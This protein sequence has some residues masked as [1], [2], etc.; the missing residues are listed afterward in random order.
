MDKDEILGQLQAVIAQRGREIELL[1]DRIRKLEARLAIYENAHTP[2][3][4]KRGGNRKKR[5]NKGVKGTPG[6]KKGHT[7]V[8]RPIAKPDKHVEVTTERCPDC[9][10]ELGSPFRIES[11]II[12]DIPEPQPVI[13]TEFK[14]AHYTCPRCQ[15]E[16]VATDADCPKEGR[17]GNNTIARATL[18]KYEDRLPHRK[19]GTALKRDYGLKVSPASILDFTRRGSDAIRSEY[20]QILE[21]IRSAPI[22]YVD[23]TGIRVQ[24]KKYWI[25]IFT[26]PEDTFVAVRKSRGMKVLMEV[27]TRRFKGI[28]VCDGW[29]PYARFTKR[30]QRCWAHLLR[31]S[32]YLAGKFA[33]AV[34]LHKALVRLYQRLDDALKDDPPPVIRERLWHE[35]RETLTQILGGEYTNEK[36]NKF[37]GKIHN[38]FEYWF[39]FVLHPGVEPTNNRA[40]RALREHVVQ[41]KI[42]GTLRNGKGTYIHE[43]VMSVLATWAQRGLNSLEMLRLRLES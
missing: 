26:T 30:I 39:T 16:I 24:G 25:W 33:D 11:E 18:L 22:L 41:R 36:V 9:G 4:L 10:T 38:G 27:L 19:I 5:Q 17:F 34:Y 12:E 21:R 43:T 14:I 13:V 1:K 32:K 3:S 6:Q 37:I 29:K 23:E 8:T 28:I 7:G 20:E 42:I 35:A 2:P 15:R 40:E 31:E